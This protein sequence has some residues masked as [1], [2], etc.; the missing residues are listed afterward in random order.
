MKI[1]QMFI[2][3]FRGEDIDENDWI[4]KDIQVNH[5]GGVILFDKNIDTSVQNFNSKE[6]LEKLTV[7]LTACSQTTLF[8]AVDQE[9]G[10]VCRLKAAYGF[11]TV[12][13]A[14]AMG[15]GG[16][17]EVRQQA[18][19]LAS[20]LKESGINLNFAPVVDLDLNP[21]NPIIGKYNRSFSVSPDKVVQCA[22]AFIEEHHKQGI[23][24]CIKHFPG[25]GSATGDSHL[26]FVDITTCWQEKELLPYSAL[27]QNGYEDGI[28]TAHLVNREL[29]STGLPATLSKKMIKNL[30]RDRFCFEG[31]VFSDDLQMSAITKGWS[32]KKAV[33]LAVIAGV[34][35][36]VVGNNLGHQEDALEQGI[37]AIEELLETNT[38]SEQQIV[39]SLKRIEKFKKK[40]KGEQP[41]KK[42]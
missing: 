34:D 23:G 1:G 42:R 24:C 11:D 20:M 7:K 12:A 33:Q 41:W 15:K 37:Q 5:L 40:I 10:R 32:Y 28:M 27:I 19:L 26:G 2:L 8:C 25:H 17:S 3:G 31:V 16:I 9:G 21:D 38:I 18:A 6:G 13:S 14:K 35:V 4:Y 36:L 39:N 22:E 29:D 30:V